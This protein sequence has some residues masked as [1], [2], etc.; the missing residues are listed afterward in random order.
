MKKQI[1]IVAIAMGM[2]VAAV[3]CGKE[4]PNE[5]TT[6]AAV[7]Q[8]TVPNIIWGKYTEGCEAPSLTQQMDIQWFLWGNSIF[9]VA[10]PTQQCVGIIPIDD[11]TA[12]VFKARMNLSEHPTKREEYRTADTVALHHWCDSMMAQDYV[13]VAYR[14][15]DGYYYAFAYTRDEWNRL[16]GRRDE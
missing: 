9:I 11:P 4:I 15:G 5:N 13:V 2:L 10:D 16:F 7:E 1:A 3:S 14:M 6:E 12:G 8:K